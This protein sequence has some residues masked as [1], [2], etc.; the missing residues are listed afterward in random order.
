M[1]PTPISLLEQ[2]RQ[3]AAGPAWDRFVLLYTPLLYNWAGRLGVEGADADDLVQ[4]VFTALLLELPRFE[5]D[6]GRR[7]R[8]W[9]WGVVRNKAR[10]RRR[11]ARVATGGGFD[12]IPDRDDADP[13]VAVDEREYRQY[14]TRRAVDLMRSDFEPVTWRAFWATAV[15]ERTAAEV[16]TDLGITENAVYLAR[17]R[18]LRRLRAELAGLLD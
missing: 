4:N 13:G 17:G 14:L 6:P 5:Y 10:D 18:V 9:L 15:E 11:V 3:P 8:G 7:F 2:L 16:A 12:A 1:T